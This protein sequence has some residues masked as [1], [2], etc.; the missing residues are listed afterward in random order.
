MIIATRSHKRG[1]VK[2]PQARTSMPHS[3]FSDDPWCRL[4]PTLHQALADPYKDHG[5]PTRPPKDQH[6]DI[7]AYWE[8]LHYLLHVLVGWQDIATGLAWWYGNGKKHLN[9]PRFQLLKALWDSEGQ[10]DD[11][12]AWA[13]K[14]K[15]WDPG[16]QFQ[17]V[18][19]E[20]APSWL[21]ETWWRTFKRRKK[22]EHSNPYDG[23]SN[24]LH[25]GHSDEYGL[26]AS[27]GDFR[28]F[29][30]PSTRQAVLVVSKIES[31]RAEL[32]TLSQ[33]LPSLGSKPWHLEVFDR[34]IGF[35]GL[36]RQSRI[37][38]RWFQGKHS[39]HMAGQ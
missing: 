27:T 39:T 31:W 20:S 26:T 5:L 10:L 9:D 22:A 32:R 8:T 18:T 21:D 1:Y 34:R 12:A 17:H 33:Q 23:G 35:L 19:P 38:H 14:T 4:I 15:G 25:L 37:T 30:E 11:Y 3:P 7:C 24:P 36:F 16:Y 13:W 6:G 28:T 29:F 2:S